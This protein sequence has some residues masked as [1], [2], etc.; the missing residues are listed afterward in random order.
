MVFDSFKEFDPV[1]L[2]VFFVYFV[3]LIGIAVIR[4]RPLREMSDYVLGGRRMSSFTSALS[5]S[6]SATS[7]W[8]MLVFPA[9]AFS[10]SAVHLW[11]GFSIVVGVWTVLGK[12]LRQYTIAEN[13]LTLPEFYEKRFGDRTGILRGLS[14]IAAIFFILFYVNSGLIAGSKLLDTVFGLE[15]TLGVL[16]TLAA[17]VSY[18][19]LGGFL[20]VSRTDVFQA[21]LML[22]G[23]IILPLT[24]IALTA[25]PFSNVGQ[26]EGF[27]N[28]MTLAEGNTINLVFFLGAA[29]WGLGFFGSHRVL[30]RFMAVENEEKITASRNISSVWITLIFSF[31]FLLGLVARPALMEIGML[32]AVSEPERVYFVAAEIF[33]VPVVTGLLLTAVVA[34]VMSTADSQLLLGSAIATDDLPLINRFAYRVRYR[35]ALGAFGRV[36]LGRLLLIII[37]LVSA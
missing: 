24:L 33:F 2:A 34:A 4:V 37:G 25:E 5:A 1:I 26:T 13:S 10:Q 23:F 18:T 32:D 19:F 12:R 14:A 7:G 27:L 16:I 15:H 3:V 35:Y 17:M 31:G 8:T 22:I 28:P 29:G 36:W 20:A 6:S 9:L 30:Q 21:M 11:T